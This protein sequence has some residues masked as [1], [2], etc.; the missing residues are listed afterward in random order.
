[1]AVVIDPVLN[2]TLG[3]VTLEDVIEE[4]IQEEI[5]DETDQQPNLVKSRSIGLFL[6][7][8]NNNT[9]LANTSTNE[10]ETQPLITTANQ[11]YGTTGAP[12][13]YDHPNT[14]S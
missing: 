12:V 6:N 2:T 4:L 13:N 8:R 14:N 9:A 5:L 3:V 1:M 11:N 7:K 10:Q